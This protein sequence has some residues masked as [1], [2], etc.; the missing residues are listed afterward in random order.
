MDVLCNCV[1]DVD[2]TRSDIHDIIQRE[3]VVLHDYLFTATSCSCQLCLQFH[4]QEE[5]ARWVREDEDCD[6]EIH[7]RGAEQSACYITVRYI[8]K[9]CNH[10]VGSR[11]KLHFSAVNIETFL[12]NMFNVSSHYF[13]FV[14]LILPFSCMICLLTSA[15]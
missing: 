5:R 13:E 8:N 11:P 4:R 2:C 3:E 6:C 15:L 10:G 1:H 7:L 14:T 9:V 12:Y